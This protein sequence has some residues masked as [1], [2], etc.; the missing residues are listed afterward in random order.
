MPGYLVGYG[1]NEGRFCGLDSKFNKWRRTLVPISTSEVSAELRV[2]RAQRVISTQLRSRL[3]SERLS[4]TSKLST[5]LSGRAQVFNNN[6]MAVFSLLVKPSLHSDVRTDL[7]DLARSAI[8]VWDVAQADERE[9]IVEPGLD[10]VG[11]KGWHDNIPESQTNILVMFPRIIARGYSRTSVSRS[12][13][14]PGRWVDPETELHILETPIYGGKG[15]TKWSEVVLEGEEEEEDWKAKEEDQKIKEK[16]RTL[17]E[18]LKKL[19]NPF[20]GTR[21]MSQM[22][23]NAGAASK[24]SAVGLKE[25][26]V[27]IKKN[28]EYTTMGQSIALIDFILAVEQENMLEVAG[29]SHLIATMPSDNL[30]FPDLVHNHDGT[31]NFDPW[32]INAKVELR[33][34]KVW[35]YT[36]KPLPLNTNAT[37]KEKHAD[38]ADMLTHHILQEV[39]DKLPAGRV[40]RCLRCV[41]SP[42]NHI[43]ANPRASVLLS[44]PRAL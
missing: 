37:L 9:V 28:I 4:S 33:P 24:P 1:Y 34:K 10:P 29:L 3:V 20:V 12:A 38:A 2:A 21:R 19:E 35:Q 17:Q 16:K 7:L 39:K 6:V 5:S 13:N 36:Q 40:R 27:T 41:P 18:D 22:E 25:G 30:K 31:Q 43:Y 32:K 15:P 42:R 14:I 8:S 11:H 44:M 23:S 26:A